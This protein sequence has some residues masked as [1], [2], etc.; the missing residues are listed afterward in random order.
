MLQTAGNPRFHLGA[1]QPL[2]GRL[3]QILAAMHW[4]VLRLHGAA[5]TVVAICIVGWLPFEKLLR[6]LSVFPQKLMAD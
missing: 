4:G 3:H 6:S 1:V 5:R 2:P